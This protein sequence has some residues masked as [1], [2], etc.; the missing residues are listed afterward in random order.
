MTSG[1]DCVGVMSVIDKRE[2]QFKQPTWD[3]LT[4][5]WS[6]LL[7]WYDMHLRENSTR[8][9]RISVNKNTNKTQR[10]IIRII[11][12]LRNWGTRCLRIPRATIYL[13][14]LCRGARNTGGRRVCLL[15][16]AAQQEKRAVWQLLGGHPRQTGEKRSEDNLPASVK[17]V[18]KC[19]GCVTG[20]A[21][22]AHP[23][24]DTPRRPLTLSYG[25][26]A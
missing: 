2:L 12:G 4:V 19:Q 23:I 10:D 22:L 18:H 5:S 13:C 8:D 26:T 1:L 16:I 24:G 15:C 21:P 20:N 3:V 14:R 6:F 11:D 17:N 9:G 7:E 25:P